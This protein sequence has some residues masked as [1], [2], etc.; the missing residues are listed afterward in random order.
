VK[1]KD[2]NIANNKNGLIS[3]ASKKAIQRAEIYRRECSSKSLLIFESKLLRLCNG[4]NF[5]VE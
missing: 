4:R 2:Y 3:N 1:V 5:F